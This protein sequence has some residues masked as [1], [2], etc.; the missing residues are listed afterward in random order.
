MDARQRTTRWPV[1]TGSLAM[2]LLLLG[3]SA[4]LADG[5]VCYSCGSWCHQQGVEKGMWYND[6]VAGWRWVGGVGWGKCPPGSACFIEVS[7]ACT[8]KCNACVAAGGSYYP[9]SGEPTYTSCTDANCSISTGK[10]DKGEPTSICTDFCSCDVGK[11]CRDTQ[12]VGGGKV[13]TQ[14]SV[15]KCPD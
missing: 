3:S 11:F 10:T 2:A 6:P 13:S 4:A 8:Q 14:N 7:A 5:Q 9:G 12:I 1:W 15:C